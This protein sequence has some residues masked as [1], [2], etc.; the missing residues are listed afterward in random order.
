MTSFVR[1][2]AAVAATPPRYLSY[3]RGHAAARQLTKL[4]GYN[5]C[6]DVLVSFC[7]KRGGLDNPGMT[8][9]CK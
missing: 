3:V 4:S 1:G 9:I 5:G 2:Y 8:K 7:F 6:S